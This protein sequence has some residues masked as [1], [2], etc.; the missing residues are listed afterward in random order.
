MQN[1]RMPV[2]RY[3][4]GG[5]R[6]PARLAAKRPMSGSVRTLVIL[7][8]VLL[9]LGI[10]FAIT[11]F[12]FASEP[13]VLP[14]GV[15]VE[16]VQVELKA[17]DGGKI[18]YTLD[19]SKPSDQSEFTDSSITLTLDKTT[20]L[21]AFTVSPGRLDSGV[22][23]QT[24]EIK[25]R[26]PYAPVIS[27]AGGTYQGAQVIYAECKAADA[28]IHY[29][30]DGSQPGIDSPVIAKDKPLALISSGVLTVQ[31]FIGGD[32]VEEPAS[33]EYTIVTATVTTSDVSVLPKAGDY[34]G[35][36]EVPLEDADRDTYFLYTTD[37]SEP[38]MY[39]EQVRGGE[40]LTFTHAGEVKMVAVRPSE[41]PSGVSQASYQIRTG[42]PKIKENVEKST[43]EKLVVD[44][45]PPSED[46]VVYY[47]LDGSDPTGQS[48]STKKKISIE[49]KKATTI[50]A[51]CKSEGR[52]DSKP[53]SKKFSMEIYRG[54]KDTGGKKVVVFTFDDGPSK[55]TAGLLDG[56]K[57]RGVRATFFML[58]CNVGRYKDTVK[59]MG[60]EGQE[61]ANHSWSHTYITKMSAKQFEKEIKD[62]ND[63]IEKYAGKRPTLFRPPGG[64][65]KNNFVP[66]S[67]K[68]VL[69]SVDT[70]DWKYRN[71]DHVYNHIINTA[72]SGDVVL[73]HDLYETSVK[74]A[75]RAID[76][77]KAEGYE[78]I[79]YSELL[80][81]H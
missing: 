37:G 7:C 5:K 64:M 22:V 42:L 27:L 70:N 31:T 80:A 47:T 68:M 78:F 62:T 16:S 51:F 29:T 19:G 77:L 74:G 60:E 8:C 58:G 45:T 67:L 76:T 53:F 44:I 69:W 11:F 32:E 71:E 65:Y 72:K 50:K 56:L 43:T 59:R 52:E 17:P 34:D 55:Y 48:Q 26:P 20:T 14:G 36:V 4:A 1:R 73:M 25:P 61:V 21:K 2:N 9:S 35:E 39:S 38:D 66:E 41:N 46:A 15:Y 24:Y 6:M 28:E 23:S 81:S 12:V 79:T 75:L 49:I 18:Y 10:F 3:R 57:K 33:E 13:R 40:K 54:F 30:L 63:V